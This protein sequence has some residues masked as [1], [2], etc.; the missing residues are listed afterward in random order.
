[1]SERDLIESGF[2]ITVYNLD[3]LSDVMY[4]IFVPFYK[5]TLLI[6]VVSCS[7]LPLVIQEC[8]MRFNMRPDASLACKFCCLCCP[9][10]K[11]LKSSIFHLFGFAPVLYRKK[12]EQKLLM[13][14]LEESV[15][16]GIPVFFLQMTNSLLL[17]RKWTLIQI[18][19]PLL[20]VFHMTSKIRTT[21]EDEERKSRVCSCC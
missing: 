21:I 11:F 16:M 18:I 6:S 1:M 12:S 14:W 15:F 7:I 5:S 2:S 10:L 13:Q 19:S 17:G 8:R 20:T 3:L 9:S 4:Y